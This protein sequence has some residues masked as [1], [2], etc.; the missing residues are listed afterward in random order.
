VASFV[1]AV[2][3][4]SFSF[5]AGSLNHVIP[6]YTYRIDNDTVHHKY[7]RTRIG[8]LSVDVVQSYDAMTRIG[9]QRNRLIV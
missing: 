7:L 3:A 2:V 1:G 8:V 6:R 5:G 9:Q 4:T